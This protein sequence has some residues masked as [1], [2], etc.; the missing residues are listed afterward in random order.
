[1][2]DLAGVCPGA[3]TGGEMVWGTYADEQFKKTFKI[4]KNTFSFIV[5]WIRNDLERQTVNEEPISP[6][7]R[8]GICLYRLG[9]GDYYYT[10]AEIAGLGVS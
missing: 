10:I 2:D 5:N 7:R 3:A 9:R 8:L 4:S 1:M 6:E